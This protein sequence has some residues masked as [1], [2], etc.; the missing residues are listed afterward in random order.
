MTLK[1]TQLQSQRRV[2]RICISFHVVLMTG[3]PC[4]M[5]IS[6]SSTVAITA[7]VL[8]VVTKVSL[9]VGCAVVVVLRWCRVLI[10]LCRDRELRL[11]GNVVIHRFLESSGLPRQGTVLSWLPVALHMG[12][13]RYVWF[14]GWMCP[15]IQRQS[16]NVVDGT[17]ERGDL[18]Q[19]LS[20]KIMF[21][22]SAQC[23]EGLVVV[24]DALPFSDVGSDSP[25]FGPLGPS[26]ALNCF[27][28]L[29]VTWAGW[30]WALRTKLSGAFVFTVVILSKRT[31]FRLILWNFRFCTGAAQTHCCWLSSTSKHKSWLWYER[32]DLLRSVRTTNSSFCKT[33]TCWN[34]LLTYQFRSVSLREGERG[35]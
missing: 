21:E 32:W 13:R 22:D 35:F 28:V 16:W 1:V 20:A 25:C 23:I 2:S 15:Q 3:D 27:D 31:I 17:A 12:A 7:L 34:L 5:L 9:T 19:A 18:G 33:S 24:Q 11:M 10:H 29:R 14:C 6:R 30:H 4:P 8:P 26:T